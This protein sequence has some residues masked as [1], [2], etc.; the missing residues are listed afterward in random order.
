MERLLTAWTGPNGFSSTDQNLTGLESGT[1]ELTVKDDSF[2][3]SIELS[4]RKN[5]NI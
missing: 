2:E 1:Y 5:R 3:K 4:C